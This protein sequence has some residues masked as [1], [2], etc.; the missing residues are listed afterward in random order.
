MLVC[1]L[2]CFQISGTLS[3]SWCSAIK[4]LLSEDDSEPLWQMIQF[5]LVCLFFFKFFVPCPHPI[6]LL[7]KSYWQ[8]LILSFCGRWS[9]SCLLIG[10]FSNFWYPLQLIMFCYQNLITN[11]DAEPLWRM[12]QFLFADWLVFQVS[13]TLSKSICSAIKKSYEQMMILRL[14]GR[15]SRSCLL[16]GWFLKFLVPSPTYIVLLSKPY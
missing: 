9:N 4:I 3:K 11:D 16:A 14:G 10:L 13:G 1:W 15:W 5:L 8:M 2:A 7:L 12:V 6:V